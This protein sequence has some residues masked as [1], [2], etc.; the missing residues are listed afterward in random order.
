[1][2]GRCSS[3]KA[4][5]QTRQRES[6]NKVPC[7]DNCPPSRQCPLAWSM[8]STATRFSICSL[9]WNRS[10]K[11]IRPTHGPDRAAFLLLILLLD[12]DR[13][14]AP[15]AYS[16]YS[17]VCIPLPLALSTE[18]RS[19]RSAKHRLELGPTRGILSLHPLREWRNGRRARLRIWSR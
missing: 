18:L 16:A 10:R 5:L 19:H 17:A 4:L 9:T 12:L 13:P 15:S 11:P 6:R 2:N 1:M 14:P 3:A 7:A 8:S